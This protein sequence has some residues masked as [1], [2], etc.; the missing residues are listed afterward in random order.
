MG[1]YLYCLIIQDYKWYNRNDFEI[2]QW[3]KECIDS[4][5]TEGMIIKFKTEEDRNLFLM[6]WGN[7]N[8]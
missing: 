2:K 5:V 8:F 4:F 1:E 3:A 7:G 6:R